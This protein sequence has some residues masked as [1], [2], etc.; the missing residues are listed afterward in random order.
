MGLDTRAGSGNDAI[1]RSD[2]QK[3]DHSIVRNTPEIS[4]KV[5]EIGCVAF[6]IVVIARSAKSL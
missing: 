5:P 6:P 4:S 2:S 3:A 1:P